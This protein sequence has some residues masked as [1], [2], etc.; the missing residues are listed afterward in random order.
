MNSSRKGRGHVHT[1]RKSEELRRAAAEDCAPPH[2]V[3][4][5]TFSEKR[6]IYIIGAGEKYI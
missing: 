1:K 2:S 3:H 6:N 4:I 5:K